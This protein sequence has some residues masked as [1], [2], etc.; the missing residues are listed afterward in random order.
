L[1][2]VDI[3]W[4]E[5]LDCGERVILASLYQCAGSVERAADPSRDRCADDG[6]IEVDLRG[7]NRRGL[8]LN[9]GSRLAGGRNR[10]LIELTRDE[11]ALHQLGVAA[12]LALRSDRRSA[13]AGERCTGTGDACVVRRG[14]DPVERLAGA[15]IVALGEEACAN[16][17]VDL[18][19]HV[20]GLVG[21][22]AARKLGGERDRLLCDD[23]YSDWRRRWGRR[24]LRA[25]VAEQEIGGE[26]KQRDEKGRKRGLKCGG[27]AADPDPEGFAGVRRTGC[28]AVQKVSIAR[29]AKLAQAA[30]SRKTQSDKDE[31]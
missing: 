15:D 8:R 22:S 16:D 5:P 7:A 25:A 27:L 4:V 21:R 1:L 20:R 19:T 24:G 31:Y 26:Q 6:A 17:A 23:D 2:D 29:G 18:R 12:D 13:G 3:D 10:I 28:G 9:V 30:E 11:V 14:V